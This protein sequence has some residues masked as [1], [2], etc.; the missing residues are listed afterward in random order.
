MFT[1]ILVLVL[2]VWNK[3]SRFVIH[4]LFLGFFRMACSTSAPSS[5]T[6]VRP[7]SHPWQDCLKGVATEQQGV[8]ILWRIPID[9]PWFT[10]NIQKKNPLHPHITNINPIHSH[11]LLMVFGFM[12]LFIDG[13]KTYIPIVSPSYTHQWLV[14]SPF[15]PDIFHYPLVNSHI[16]MENQHF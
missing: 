15:I 14:C 9:F 6:S 7:G 5:S 11:I 2:F 3:H 13:W 1:K 4:P 10:F 12:F 8:A 16:T